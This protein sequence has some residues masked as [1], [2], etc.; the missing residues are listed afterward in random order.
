MGVNYGK[1]KHNL[2][3]HKR[4]VIKLHQKQ[5]IFPYAQHNND[6]LQLSVSTLLQFNMAIDVRGRKKTH[7][8]QKTNKPERKIY[9]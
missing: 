6:A 2:Q 8:K 1:Y 9:V 3:R 5:E 4:H 7:T